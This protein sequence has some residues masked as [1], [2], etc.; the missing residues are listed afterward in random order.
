[1]SDA[2]D[3]PSRRYVS[4]LRLSAEGLVLPSPEGDERRRLLASLDED[5]CCS[6]DEW[7]QA[8]FVVVKGSKCHFHDVLGVPQ[9]TKEQVVK[10]ADYYPSVRKI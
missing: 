1:M 7:R 3:E 9:F 5:S 6:F 4:R 8:G 2:S 10:R